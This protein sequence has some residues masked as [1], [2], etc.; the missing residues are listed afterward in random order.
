[1]CQS[2]ASFHTLDFFFFSCWKKSAELFKYLCARK[3]QNTNWRRP[4][5]GDQ[6][7]DT[8]TVIAAVRAG[9]THNSVKSVCRVQGRDTEAGDMMSLLNEVWQCKALF[10][11]HRGVKDQNYI[12][13]ILC[14]FMRYHVHVFTVDYSIFAW[15]I[16]NVCSACLNVWLSQSFYAHLYWKYE[17]VYSVCLQRPSCAGLLFGV[18]WT[19]EEL[20]WG[21]FLTTKQHY[22]G[23]FF[24]S[25]FNTRWLLLLIGALMCV[26]GKGSVRRIHYCRE[27]WRT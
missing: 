1:M 24:I 9:V 21:G 19:L 20:I 25:H 26:D 6:G 14:C 15:W 18:Q 2:G 27:K 17:C 13:I 5:Q 12:Q 23:V 16:S 10:S 11:H 22:C 8:H 3:T 4:R 7:S